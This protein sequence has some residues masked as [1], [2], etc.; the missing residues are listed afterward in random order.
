MTPENSETLQRVAGVITRTFP[1]VTPQSITRETVASDIPGWDSLSHSL[2]IMGIEEEYGIELPFE[3]I[4]DLQNV[5]ALAD[6][7]DRVKKA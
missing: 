6:L 7:V 3:E 4:A 2:V 1:S 5:G